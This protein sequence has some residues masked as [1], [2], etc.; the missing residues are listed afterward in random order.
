MTKYFNQICF[1]I[2][3]TNNPEEETVQKSIHIHM[4]HPQSTIPHVS[5]LLVITHILVLNNN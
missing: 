3:S 2:D 1:N 5:V 4:K